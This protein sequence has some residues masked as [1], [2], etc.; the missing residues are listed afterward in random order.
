MLLLGVVLAYSLG[1]ALF[2]GKLRYRI[3][4]LPCVAI[5]AAVGTVG[6]ASATGAL[7]ISRAPTRIRPRR[8]TMKSVLIITR[9]DYR[10]EP[11]QRFH[12]QV[13]YWAPRV[14]RVT[15]LFRRWNT[16]RSLRELGRALLTFRTDVT[17]EGSVQLVEV[18]PPWN[19]PRGFGVTYIGFLQDFIDVV[20]LFRRV[21]A[22][23]P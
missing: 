12:Q 17:R 21:R 9:L 2:V 6:L 7:R 5:F 23:C 4:V 11:H 15:V 8:G 1:F 3:V 22:A 18:D 14:E 19:L 20:S 10:R 16:G 13:R